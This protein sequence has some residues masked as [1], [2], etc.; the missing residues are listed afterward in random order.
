MKANGLPHHSEG[1]PSLGEA[2]LVLAATLRAANP[3]RPSHAASASSACPP[4]RRTQAVLPQ[5]PMSALDA[6]TQ[7]MG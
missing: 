4:F 6:S 7:F 5:A 3:A 2:S 1:M